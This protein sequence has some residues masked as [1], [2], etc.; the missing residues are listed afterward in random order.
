MEDYIN[1][2]EK[3][4]TKIIERAL[5]KKTGMKKEKDEVINQVV[6]EQRQHNINIINDVTESGNL[7]RPLNDD[8]QIAAEPFECYKWEGFDHSICDFFGS[9]KTILIG[10]YKG[11][12]YEDW[13]RTHNIYTIRL[14]DT[15]GS[16]EA[17]RE[18][19]DSTSL[20][21]LYEL[22]KPNNLSAYKIIGNQEMGKEEL[23]AMDYPKK[24]PRKSYMTFSITPLEMDL[25][26]LVEHHLV[27]RLI[28]LNS[29][30]AKGTPVFI[31]P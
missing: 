7:S 11:K 23:L 21:V 24:E 18:L 30:N 20:L 6:E 17:N 29:E 14:G 4:Q 15:K 5:K 25:T 9:D 28:E 12:K 27:E 13:I 8:Y 3:A 22:G 1:E 2:V 26:F 19:F 10:C 16:M 31:Q